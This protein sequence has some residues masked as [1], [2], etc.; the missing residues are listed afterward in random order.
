MI[1]PRWRKI[2]RD[3]WR[4][5]RRTVLVVLSI[6]VGVFAVGTVAIMRDI[7][8]GDMV[9]SYEAANPPSAILYVDGS[10]DDKMVESIKRIPQVAEVE[11]R[12][13]IYVRFQHPQSDTWYAMRLYTAPDYENMRIG[14]LRPEEVFGMDPDRWPEPGVY[15]PPDRQILIERTSVLP[16]LALGLAPD[17]RQGDTVR[18]ETP[19]GAIREMA[20]A[21]MVYDSVHGSAPW[22]GMAY[23]YVTRDTAE[24]LG[25]PRTYNEL[26]MRV[27]GDR[28]DVNHIEEVAA[29]IENRLERSGL[30]VTRVQIPTP[31][32]LPQDGI[33]QALV[34]LLTVL[35]VASLFLSVF[36]LVNTV[37]ALLT[38]QVRQIGV[39]K[40]IGARTGQIVRL[41]LGM[42][43]LFGLAALAIAAPLSVWAGRYIINF[44]SLL[45][46]FTLGGFRL[47]PSVLLIQ[48][49]LAILVPLVAGLVPILSGARITVREAITSY[50]VSSS[51]F[52]RSRI[53][54]LVKGLTGLPAPIAL[55]F[56]NT[57]RN[58]SRLVLTLITLSLA[59]T[60][61]IAVLNVR[62]SLQQTMEE[63]IQYWA[64]D[65]S[66]DL[67]QPY[68]LSRLES[69]ALGVPGVEIVEGWAT[70]SSYRVRPDG[71]AGEDIYLQAPP[72]GSVM[73]NPI[74]EEG[75]WL[76]PGDDNALV[77]S[78]N[79]LTEEPDLKM[80]DELVLKINNDETQWQIVG[81]VR[82][83]A[84]VAF[85]YM[86]NEYLAPLLGTPGR[87]SGLRII[88]DRHDSA[89][90]T[91][92]AEALEAQFA[93]AG[94]DV[95]AVQ[96]IS[97]ARASSEMLFQIVIML[98]M[99]MAI[100]LAAV[101]GI[102]LAGTMSLNVLERI[103]EVGVLRAIGAGHGAVL[104]VVIVE[105]VL[106]GLLS[107]VA[108]A[109]LAYPVG[110]PIA[111]AVGV[112]TVGMA[113]S[114][115]VSIGGMLFWLAAV[116]VISAV[117]SYFPA[118]Q[119]ANLSVRQVLAYEQ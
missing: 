2:L 14:I 30:D 118:Q 93:E 67:N 74:L 32:K 119:A 69:I 34:I 19:S 15:P 88:T 113:V 13:Q 116:V 57:F 96:T 16:G 47:S 82:Y 44:M 108:G 68:R 90:R 75:R 109:L 24:W 3:I 94:L 87:V 102:G 107:W 27:T 63:M 4:N 60:I 64:Y 1:R 105:G 83:A 106:I 80:G 111:N 58:K 52:G 50:G 20:L 89:S 7:V 85:A 28:Y 65:V 100:L 22:T 43:I 18:V 38:Q 114:Y 78:A 56:R 77:V 9:A 76:A 99:S 45:V 11:G 37:S 36:L 25:Y 81:V 54:R 51:E 17:A 112:A 95:G 117:A 8:T 21:G 48:A 92:I 110:K 39:M 84:P 33:F 10:F 72:A 29:E 5:K 42:V 46:D 98:L 104:Q 86:N 59:G 115:K 79:L 62:A 61:F 70:G 53:D 41:Y 103:R 91:R 35:G 71:S 66:V 31:G 55:S 12:R 73:I 97:Q 101:G 26:H 40:T 49:G 6:A 23:G